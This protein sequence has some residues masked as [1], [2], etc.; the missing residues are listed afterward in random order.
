MPA[1]LNNVV[2]G[3]QQEGEYIKLPSFSALKSQ[4]RGQNRITTQVRLWCDH[5]CALTPLYSPRADR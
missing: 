4:I 2:L 3:S 5:I 1:D